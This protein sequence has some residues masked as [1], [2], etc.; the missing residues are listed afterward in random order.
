LADKKDYDVFATKYPMNGELK[1]QDEKVAAMDAWCKKMTIAATPTY[2]LN[3][4]PLPDAY[5]IY[6][7]TYF[8]AE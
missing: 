5:S 7:L 3:G 1:Q 6:D 4:Y 8:L 2:F